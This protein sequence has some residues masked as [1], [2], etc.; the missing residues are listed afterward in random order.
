MTN[1]PA[2]ATHTTTFRS[3]TPRRTTTADITGRQMPEKGSRTHNP[4][5]GSSVR[6]LLF[7]R[8]I[9]DGDADFE[10][11]MLFADRGST[12][13]KDGG[14]VPPSSPGRFPS[15][16]HVQFSSE[17]GGKQGVSDVF[18]VFGLVRGTFCGGGG[19]EPA[20]V[21]LSFSVLAGW[22][23]FAL[24]RGDSWLYRW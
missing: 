1:D 4:R 14:I 5:R 13:I 22:H 23:A 12:K 20:A 3:S 19:V 8:R 9:V 17:G 21:F 16:G 18:D 10:W 24:L 6:L 2:D 15:S 7:A 11:P